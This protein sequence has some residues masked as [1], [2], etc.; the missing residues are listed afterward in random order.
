MSKSIGE[1]LGAIGSYLLSAFA[2]ISGYSE[3]IGVISGLA[4]AILTLSMALEHYANY[5][6]TL[7]QA[8]AEERRLE[9]IETG[10]L[11]REKEEHEN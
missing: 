8:R 11:D 3:L 5:R 10:E 2:F 6:K 7:A 1:G 9:E 4:G